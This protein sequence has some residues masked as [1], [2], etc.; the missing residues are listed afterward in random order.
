MYVPVS[1]CEVAVCICDVIGTVLVLLL[2]PPILAR[3]AL[4]TIATDITDDD[5]IALDCS[6]TNIR[7]FLIIL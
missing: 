2:E 6:S 4:L 1:E 7:E 5:I 3:N